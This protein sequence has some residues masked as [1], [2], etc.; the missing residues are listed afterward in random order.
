MI[1]AIIPARAG[2]KGIE[3]KNIKSFLGKPLIEWVIRAVEGAGIVPVVATDGD[4]IADIALGLGAEVFRWSKESAGDL[5]PTEHVVFEWMDK[6][7][8]SDI[9]IVAQATSPYTTSSDIVRVMNMIGSYDSVVSVQRVYRFF[10]EDSPSGVYAMNYTPSDRP[11]RQNNK[12]VLMENGALYVS[13][14][15][16]M[17]ESGCR[18]SGKIGAWEMD[19]GFELDS[20][21]DWKIGE[22]IM[23]E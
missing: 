3:S 5:T 12:G 16:A 15:G 13:T 18:V 6:F 1:R 19:Y 22:K 17:V 7:D 11:M 21:E 14:V 20:L 10:W 9:V 8:S 23:G 4:E 2:S